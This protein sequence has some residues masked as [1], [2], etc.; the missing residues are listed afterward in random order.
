MKIKPASLSQSPAEVSLYT[1][2]TQAKQGERN[3]PACQLE[4]LDLPRTF[5]PTGA[6]RLIARF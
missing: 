3:K 1:G 4:S 5:K 6:L 2:Y